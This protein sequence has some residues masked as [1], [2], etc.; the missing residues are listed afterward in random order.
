[1]RDNDAPAIEEFAD[2]APEDYNQDVEGVPSSL[3]DVSGD[4]FPPDAAGAESALPPET[5]SSAPDPYAALDVALDAAASQGTAV[6]RQAYRGLSDAERK[7]FAAAFERRFV[8]KAQAV[9]AAK[10]TSPDAA[11][12]A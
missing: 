10:P 2:P 12:A 7:H 8:P 1:M 11:S 5:P 3:D 9:D 4:P 6:L